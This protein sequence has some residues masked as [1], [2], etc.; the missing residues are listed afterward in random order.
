MADGKGYSLVIVVQETDEFSQLSWVNFTFKK[1]ESNSF[2]IKF[3][4]SGTVPTTLTNNTFN[5][6]DIFLD[7]NTKEISNLCNK[8]QKSVPTI[9]ESN[10]NENKKGQTDCWSL[11]N[12]H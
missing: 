8:L 10:F 1:E 5:L 6:V 11:S 7:P 9:I 2:E 12:L 4:A 3:V